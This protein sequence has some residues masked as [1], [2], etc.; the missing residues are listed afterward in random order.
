MRIPPLAPA[1]LNPDQRVLYDDMAD[2]IRRD[3]SGFKAMDESSALIGPFNVWMREPKWGR[4]I[5]DLVK[6]MST[7]PTLPRSV[8]EIAIL[9][10]GAHF[11]AAYEIYAHVVLAEHRGLADEKIATIIVGQ[12]PS[13]LAPDEAI[14]Y[15]VA[16]AL[17]SGHVLPTLTYRRAVDAFG[18]SSAMELIYLVGLYCF[19]SVTL[20]GFDVPLPE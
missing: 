13:D 10:T 16:S 20:N 18:E 2:E 15:D 5:W 12:R 3:F 19:V 11:R 9:V 17:V 1:Q 8:R 7:S 14:A 4:A 6:A